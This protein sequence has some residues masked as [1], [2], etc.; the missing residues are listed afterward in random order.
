MCAWSLLA[1][2]MSLAVEAWT[3]GQSVCHTVL[4]YMK[5]KT[6]GQSISL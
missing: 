5:Q 6:L 4:I 3:L 1:V 2:T